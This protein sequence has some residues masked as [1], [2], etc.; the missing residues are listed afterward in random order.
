MM[1]HVVS[2]QPAWNG[3]PPPTFPWGVFISASGFGTLGFG[4]KNT[5]IDIFFSS[6]MMVNLIKVSS[7]LKILLP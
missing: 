3:I 7:S 4:K 5:Q 2:T 6:K 1:P